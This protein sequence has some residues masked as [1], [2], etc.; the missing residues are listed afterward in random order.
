[1]TLKLLEEGPL[2]IGM[3]QGV[4]DKMAH[5]ADPRRP[6][7]GLKSGLDH[8]LLAIGAA[9]THYVRG[10]PTA[11]E[12]R[13]ENRVDPCTVP[14]LAQAQA[15]DLNL[16]QRQGL[17][18]AEGRDWDPQH[19]EGFLAPNLNRKIG[20]AHPWLIEVALSLL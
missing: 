13:E 6:I 1:Q 5:I 18:L 12:K 17:A 19:D 15:N 10:P 11:L 2:G 20:D 4:G 14:C 3:L 8:A 16:F 7:G 9:V